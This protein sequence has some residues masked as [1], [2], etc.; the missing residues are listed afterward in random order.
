MQ[1]KT[2]G[3]GTVT[4]QVKWTK[5]RVE[6]SPSLKVPLPSLQVLGV[7]S[8]KYSWL[9]CKYPMFLEHWTLLVIE[10]GVG[11]CQWLSSNS[12][13]ELL[14]SPNKIV[15]LQVI[16]SGWLSSVSHAAQEMCALWYKSPDVLWT[17]NFQGVHGL[18]QPGN[19]HWPPF[20]TL[21]HKELTLWAS[22]ASPFLQGW[23]WNYQAPN[24]PSC[25]GN[26]CVRFSGQPLMEGWWRESLT[27]IKELWWI[28]IKR[29]SHFFPS[30]LISWT[31]LKGELSFFFFV[32]NG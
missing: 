1:C 6:S 11:Y 24:Y 17:N 28:K 27:L 25:S 12:L 32:G 18:L 3:F 10:V 8:V 20:W 9:E 22:L 5:R 13:H 29:T 31:K 23:T 4:L 26:L 15:S 2:L 16:T 7:K 21:L 14:L 30:K 19:Y